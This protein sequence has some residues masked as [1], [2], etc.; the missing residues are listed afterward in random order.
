MGRGK[1]KAEGSCLQPLIRHNPNVFSTR[2]VQKV[3]HRLRHV[4]RVT[5][6]SLTFQGSRRSRGGVWGS[7]PGVWKGPIFRQTI[8]LAYR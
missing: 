3:L 5:S 1:V 8:R 4:S 7:R 6:K 2:Q